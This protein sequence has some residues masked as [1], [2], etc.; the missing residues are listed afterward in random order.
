MNTAALSPSPGGGGVGPLL[1]KSVIAGGGLA[2]RLLGGRVH[3]AGLL[4]VTATAVAAAAVSCPGAIGCFGLLA[5]ALQ[6][7][8]GVA[9]RVLQHWST[10]V[11]T[12]VKTT[13]FQ[14]WIQLWFE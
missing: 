3:H 6:Q 8:V 5:L 9:V 14:R 7:G 1:T 2:V 4:V 11:Y 10:H 13:P 12:H